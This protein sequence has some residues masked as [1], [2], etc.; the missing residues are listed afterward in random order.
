MA[1]SVVQDHGTVVAVRGSIIDVELATVL[2]EGQ[3]VL[4]LGDDVVAE[5]FAHV[6]SVTVRCLALTATQGLARGAPARPEGGAIRVPVGPGLR[7][8]AIDVL[9]HPIDGKGEIDAEAWRA[10][11]Q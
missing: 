8:R 7:G 10:I 3:D 1:L 4:H 11:Y 2:P 6:D 9:G 5:V